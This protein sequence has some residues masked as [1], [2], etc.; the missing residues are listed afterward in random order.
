MKR[1]LMNGLEG[2]SGGCDEDAG[3]LEL[4]WSLTFEKNERERGACETSP[5]RESEWL[6]EPYL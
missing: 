4:S 3:F 5:V 6:K 2:G 1:E